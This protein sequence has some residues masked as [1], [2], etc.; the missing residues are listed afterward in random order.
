MDLKQRFTEEISSDGLDLFNL[1]FYVVEYLRSL[2][3]DVQ[4]GIIELLYKVDY[5]FFL[6]DDEKNYIEVIGGVVKINNPFFFAIALEI[7]ENTKPIYV[8]IEEI[9]IEK[10]LDYIKQKQTLRNYDR[11]N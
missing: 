6:N 10:Y 1:S 2:P 9:N 4:I 7:Q 5:N 3:K 8:L 11:T